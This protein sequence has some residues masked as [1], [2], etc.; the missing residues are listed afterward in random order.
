M[1]YSN[2]QMAQQND[3]SSRG[4]GLFYNLYGQSATASAMTA[5]AWGVSRI[6]DVLEKMPSAH[7]N[8]KRIAVTGC[9]RD[10]KGA[11]MAGAL[12][13]RIALTIPQESGSGGDACWRLSL[14]EQQQ[15]SVV[16]TATE[17]VTENVWFSSNFANYVNN[18]SVLP[19]DHHMLAAL[20]APRPMISFE[21]TD[22]VWLSPLSSFGCMTAAHTVWDALGVADK[23]GF[24]QVGG[25]AHCAWPSSLS[26]QL[27]AFFD[28]FLLDQPNVNTSFF[29]TNGVFGGVAWTASDWI[30][31]TTPT[32]N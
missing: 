20:I 27:N 11:L 10:G 32:L 7:I 21:N 31:W 30:N 16:Q 2:S 29:A 3:A 15:G 4:L 17:I 1:I 23:H 18:L 28:R 13:P 25:H 6:I 24:E 5:W 8:T 19:F 26:P 9:S 12:E 22:Y 14:Y